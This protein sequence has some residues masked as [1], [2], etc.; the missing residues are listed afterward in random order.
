MGSKVV[1][2]GSESIYAAARAWVDCALRSDGSLFTPGEPVWSRELL[3]ELHT[4][5]LDQ[6]DESGRPFLEKLVDQLEGSPPEVYQLMGEV[7]YVHYLPLGTNQLA[8]HTVLGWSANPVEIPPRLAA[9]SRSRLINI[10]AGHNYIAY[11]V[12]TLIEVV[13]QWKELPQ[14][15]RYRLSRDPRAFKDFLFSLRFSSEMLVNNQNR[16]DLERHLLLHIV[17][18]DTFETIV[19]NDKRR[20]ATADEFGRFV[21]RTTDDIDRNIAQIRE[22]LENELDKDFGFHDDDIRPFW[23]GGAREDPWDSF[24]ARAR[25]YLDTDTL[26]KDELLYK[27]EIGQKLAD[28]RRGVLESSDDWATMVKRGIGGN[29]IHRVSQAKF[30]DWLD[31]APDDALSALR[32]LWSDAPSDLAGRVRGFCDLFPPS[33]TNGTGSRATVASVLLMGLDP[34]QFPPFRT[35]AFDDSVRT[36]RIRQTREG[37]GRRTDI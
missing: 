26:E 5:F 30:R 15:R 6:P 36:Y 8:V 16:G 18:P 34:E 13:E 14:N 2:E 35:M 21:D 32:V 23:R 11:Q 3:R 1:Q 31:E 24:I 17:F 22:G 10:G 4:R 37:I 12:A 9:V 33:A 29:L 19:G 28:A 27:I 20:I 25:A 7:L